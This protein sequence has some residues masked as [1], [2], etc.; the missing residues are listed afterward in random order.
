MAQTTGTTRKTKGAA[1]NKPQTKG[2]KHDEHNRTIEDVLDDLSGK[3]RGSKTAQKKR[4][5]NLQQVESEFMASTPSKVTK[6]VNDTNI[7]AGINP[8]HN[9]YSSEAVWEM[10]REMM[11]TMMM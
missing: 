9:P 2:K 5:L 10:M 1:S 11:T 4:Q 6:T 3:K 8:T 7:L